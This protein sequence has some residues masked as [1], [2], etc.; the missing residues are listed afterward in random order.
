MQSLYLIKIKI[1]ANSLFNQLN[2]INLIKLNLNLNLN[3]V[4]IAN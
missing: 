4:N 2:D 1:S 3:S